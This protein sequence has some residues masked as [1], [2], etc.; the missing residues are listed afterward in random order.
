MPR[1]PRSADLRLHQ[2][3]QV[4]PQRGDLNRHDDHIKAVCLT[5]DDP[6][7]GDA[8]GLW[9]EALLLIKRSDLPRV[10]GILNVAELTRPIVIH[11]VQHIFHPPVMLKAWPSADRRSRIVFIARGL[12]EAMLRDTLE[13][14][15]QQDAPQGPGSDGPPSGGPP[16][17]RDDLTT[18]TIRLRLRRRAWPRPPSAP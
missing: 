18:A 14:F 12:D 9:L 8:L 11:G 17:D 3:A 4:R 15:T 6:V 16:P 1:R 13:F 10:K 5:L 2:R 7:A